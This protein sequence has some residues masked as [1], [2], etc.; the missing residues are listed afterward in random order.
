MAHRS[1]HP[2][3]QLNDEIG[4]I[5]STLADLS[6]KLSAAVSP[7]IAKDA[8]ELAVKEEIVRS[9]IRHRR[10][11][12]L[13]FANDLFADPAWDMMLEL[14]LAEIIQQRVTVSNLCDAAGVP[15]TT[16]LRWQKAMVDRG[17]FVRISDPVDAR[18]IYVELA[19]EASVGLRRYF[20][21]VQSTADKRL[22]P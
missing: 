7:T 19:P 21:E 9:A 22:R 18:R 5:A 6:S 3:Y 13:Y 15:P 1:A 16:A 2:S 20:A 8:D 10:L 14:L 12:E 11:R 4:R 17:L